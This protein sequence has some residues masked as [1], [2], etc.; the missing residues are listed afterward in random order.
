[1]CFLEFLKLNGGQYP[2][3]AAS[4]AKS[5]DAKRSDPNRDYP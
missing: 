4:A 3:V 2:V 1:M 5:R